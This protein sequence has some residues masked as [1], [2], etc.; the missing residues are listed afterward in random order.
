MAAK[1]KHRTYSKSVTIERL[2]GTDDA[3][4]QID[5]SKYANWASYL[6]TWCA[7][8]SK[9]GREFWKV[10]QT[11]ATVTHVW[12]ATWSSTLALA[13]PDMR[14]I[15]EGNTY[16]IVSVIDIDLAH[17]EVEIQTRQMVQ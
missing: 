10:Q 3:H 7:V 12:Y 17:N 8:I 6:K 13:T 5:V 9:G 1:C 11:N 14:L 4:G 16:E 15:C 2:S